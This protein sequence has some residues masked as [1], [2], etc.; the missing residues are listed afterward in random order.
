M[1]QNQDGK[2]SNKNCPR[3]NC[4]W[5]SGRLHV[6]RLQSGKRMYACWFLNSSFLF[7]L[8]R[9]AKLTFIQFHFIC[10]LNFFRNCGRFIHKVK[11]FMNF[12]L[13]EGD[14]GNFT[15]CWF[16]P[17]NSEMVKDLILQSVAAH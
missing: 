15:T 8:L 10:W 2:K 4:P 17:N 1:P 16:S 6:C 14:G 12:N 9:E 13:G 5:G 7:Y 3:G 11:L